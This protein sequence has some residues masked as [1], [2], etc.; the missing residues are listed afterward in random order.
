LGEYWLFSKAAASVTGLNVEPT[1]RPLL[2]T[3]GPIVARSRPRKSRPVPL[4]IAGTA[5]VRGSI[6]VI[7]AWNVGANRPTVLSTAACA[8]ACSSGW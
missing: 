6:T 1:N 8:F 5:P 2:G 4:T 7:A 3:I